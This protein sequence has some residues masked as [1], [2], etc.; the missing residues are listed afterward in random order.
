MFIRAVKPAY[1]AAGHGRRLIGWNPSSTGPVR[2]VGGGLVTLRNRARDAA[3][4]EPLAAAIIRAWVSALV[5]SGI[6]CRTPTDNPSSRKRIDSL[7]R[8][9]LPEADAS[10]GSGDF[11]GLQ[12]MAVRGFIESGEVFIRLRPRYPEDGLAVPLQ[13]DLLEADML[14]QLDRVEPNGNEIRQGIEFNKIGRRVAYHFLKEHPGDG[15]GDTSS[16]TRVPAEFISHVYA[17]ERPGQIRGVSVLAPV[18]TSLKNLGDFVDAASERAKLANLVVGFVTRPPSVGDPAIN[19][20]IGKEDGIDDSGVPVASL[21]PGTMQELLPGESVQ[22]SD[23]PQ[24]GAEFAEFVRTQISQIASGAGGIPAEY[25][26]GDLRDVSDRTLRVSLNE[27][28][29]VCEGVQWQ[30]VIPKICNFVRN[31]WADAA[32]MAGSLNSNEAEIAR[33]CEWTPPRHRHLHP[34][35]DVQGLR[36][37]I[38]AGL[39]SRASVIAEYGYDAVDV[40]AE[41]A[42]DAAREAALGLGSDESKLAEAERQKLLAETEAAVRQADAAKAATKEAAASTA[43]IQIERATAQETRSFA[44]AKAKD[45]AAAARLDLEAARLGLAELQGQP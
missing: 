1:D 18:L 25:L 16:T 31:A 35:Q 7:W 29:R 17:P 36:I 45:E 33:R 5:G 28:R 40:D 6:V 37:E 30:I 22:F 10:G 27:W 23:P 4:N 38:E 11:Y 14:P 9:W 44:V 42:S 3:R 34:T 41:R 13:I 2:A 20:L 32:L 43:R 12:T 21:E 8:D 26:S 24:P 15:R 19:T 39:R